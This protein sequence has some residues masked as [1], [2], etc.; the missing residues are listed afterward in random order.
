[1]GCT[2]PG[3][4]VLLIMGIFFLLPGLGLLYLGLRFQIVPFIL[5]GFGISAVGIGLLVPCIRFL[6]RK[7]KA[8]SGHYVSAVIIGYDRKDN[9]KVNG[10]H[11]YSFTC[12]GDGRSFT[13]QSVRYRD[14]DDWLGMHV[15]VYVSDEDPNTY[16]VDE[17]T[18]C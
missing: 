17:K 18:I 4:S 7:R 8:K 5:S 11:A 15:I 10:K 13:F 16:Y 12:E 14:P 3:F 6:M 2:M 9:L 1:M